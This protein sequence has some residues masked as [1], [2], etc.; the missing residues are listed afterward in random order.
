MSTNAGSSA[1][2]D[3]THD[4]AVDGPRDGKRLLEI[5]D[6]EVSFPARHA[7]AEAVRGVN[8]EIRPGQMHA[9]VGESGS[10][11]SVTARTILRIGVPP[12]RIG[13]GRIDFEGRDILQLSMEELRALRGND[14]AMVFQEPGRYLNPSLTVGRQIEEMLTLHRD[15]TPAAARRRAEELLR[16]VELPRPRSVLRSYPHELSGGMK[17]R[18]MIAMA[19]SCEP[20]LLL[21]DEPVTAL[22]VTVQRQI[23]DL[24]LKLKD[25]LHMAVLFVSHD[26]GVVQSVADWISV[27]YAGRIVESAPARAFFERPLH[28]Y[29]QLLLLSIPSAERRDRELSSIRG[30]VP[31]AEA[32][33]T[34]CAFHPRCPLAIER[35]RRELPPD[36]FY[37]TAHVA[38]CHRIEEHT[39]LHGWDATWTDG[40]VSG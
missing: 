5:R 2:P 40:R 24:L 36:L 17:Q 30:R 38:A 3:N 23:L 27:M 10:G 20:K 13:R 7:V 26:L 11:K 18:A 19:I 16:L 4:T 34:G 31:D 32:V 28:P 15:M 25:A 39:G 33:P 37:E 8:L 29:S 1:T 21:A 35:C 14:I 12:A 9:L 22:D 6:L